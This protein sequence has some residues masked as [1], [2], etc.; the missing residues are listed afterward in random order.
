ML[1]DRNAKGILLPIETNDYKLLMLTAVQ[2]TTCD[3]FCTVLTPLACL[4]QRKAA[5]NG[6]GDR[7]KYSHE[8]LCR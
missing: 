5:K 1:S 4:S 7:D 2:Q 3:K 6:S 8:E